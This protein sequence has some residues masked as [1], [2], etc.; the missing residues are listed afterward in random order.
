MM[1]TGTK[2]TIEKIKTE[3]KKIEEAF[4]SGPPCLNKLA[5]TGFGE[6]SRNNALFNI[7]VYYKQA[8][9]MFGKMRL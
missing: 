9:Q 2:E 4:P 5:T 1:F 3:E 6:G 8:H 7:A